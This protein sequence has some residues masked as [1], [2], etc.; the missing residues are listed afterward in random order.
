MQDEW[1]D[2]LA[3]VASLAS[4]SSSTSFNKASFS[5]GDVSGLQNGRGRGRGVR[6]E[7]GGA[8]SG[9]AREG[10][11][12]GG[13]GKGAV[14]VGDDGVDGVEVVKLQYEN[15]A[16]QQQVCVWCGLV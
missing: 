10:R 14:G 2:L 7:G 1:Q 3:L 8:A 11:K 16:L 13:K 4:A 9:G 15:A 5:E 12:G 6:V